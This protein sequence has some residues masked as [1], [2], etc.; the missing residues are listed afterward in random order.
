[1]GVAVSML[2]IVLV[3]LLL[4]VGFIIAGIFLWRNHGRR[5]AHPLIRYGMAIPVNWRAIALA[6]M[7]LGGILLFWVVWSVVEWVR[8]TA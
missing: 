8:F 5:G 7:V 1:M 2:L 4:S 3:I 6:L